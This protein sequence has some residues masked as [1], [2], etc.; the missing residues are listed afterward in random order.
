[1]TQ[2]RSSTAPTLVERALR[3]AP[4][5]TVDRASEVGIREL[6]EFRDAHRAWPRGER[7]TALREAA[8]EFRGRFLEQPQVRAVRTVDLVSAAYP[9]SFAFHGAARGLNPYVNIINRLVIVQFE[10]FDGRPR[11]LAWEP[12][13]AEGA[14]EAPFYDQMLKR[15]GEFLS[16]KV[17]ATFYNTVEQA[18]AAA[19][20]S[21]A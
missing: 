4:M 14:A 3:C 8:A 16:Y 20:V 10:D 9:A 17:F 18:V 15:Y 13:I 6:T 7:P 21:P 5:A 19:G 11:T 2:A 1:M 12:T